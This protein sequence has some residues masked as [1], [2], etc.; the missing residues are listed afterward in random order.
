MF[1]SKT[2][3]KR[4]RA[5]GTTGDTDNAEIGPE[6]LA[7][8][9]TSGS[10]ERP[11]HRQKG[12]RIAGEAAM[13]MCGSGEGPGTPSPGHGAASG[14]V[15]ATI[16]RTP[17]HPTGR[18]NPLMGERR[19]GTRTCIENKSINSPKGG[20]SNTQDSSPDPSIPL[21]PSPWAESTRGKEPEGRQPVDDPHEKAAETRS[22]DPV[23]MIAFITTR[24][25]LVPLIEGLCAQIYFR[26]EIS[27]VCSHL[28]FFFL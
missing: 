17:P 14:E 23:M 3:G 25:S 19:K 7:R 18:E 8:Q 26:F 15:K 10:K 13:V 22:L 24:S 21:L 28:L 16:S 12:P 11:P 9:D 4:P 6:Q 2:T 5:D 20:S 1:R 27:V